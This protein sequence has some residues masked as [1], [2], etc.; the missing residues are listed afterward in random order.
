MSLSPKERSKLWRDR[1]KKQREEAKGQMRR[2]LGT[3]FQTPF[4]DWFERNGNTSDFQFVLLMAGIE[5]PEFTDDRG[6]EDFV[7]DEAMPSGDD[8][9]SGRARSLGRAQVMVGCLLDAASTLAGI[10]NSY[11]KAEITE[12]II[13]L[14]KSEMTDPKKRRSSLDE[15]IRLSKMRDRLEKQVHWPIPRWEVNAD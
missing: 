12:R 5:P 11:L 6:P 3:T 7:I 4:A 9:F 2:E 1:Q 8:P 14:E 13:T 15:I 10:T